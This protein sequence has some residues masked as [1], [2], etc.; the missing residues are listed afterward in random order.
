MH[1]GTCDESMDLDAFVEVPVRVVI[2]HAIEPPD[3][4]PPCRIVVGEPGNE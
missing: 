4:G 2:T 1:L 3:N